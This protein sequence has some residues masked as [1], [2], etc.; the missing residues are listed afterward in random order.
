M[1]TERSGEFYHEAEV[2]VAV[3]TGCV[4]VEIVVTAWH[5][6]CRLVDLKIQLAR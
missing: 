6:K 4:E 3:G 5:S 1:N 2:S